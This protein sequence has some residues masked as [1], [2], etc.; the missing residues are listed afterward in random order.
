MK[1][2]GTVQNVIHD[3]TILIKSS[4]A[5]RPGTPVFDS[6]GQ[7]I[8]TVTRTFGPVEGPYVSVK[9][10]G[11]V[12]SIGMLNTSLYAGDFKPGTRKKGV[13]KRQR[14]GKPQRR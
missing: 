7:E 9:P 4:K 10:S 8:G 14:K 5:F 1:K 12:D 6:R 11:R 13:N 2:I 3:G